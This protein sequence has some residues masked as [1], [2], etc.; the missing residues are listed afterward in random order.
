MKNTVECWMAFSRL[1]G[2]LAHGGWYGYHLEDLGVVADTDIAPVITQNRKSILGAVR[3]FNAQIRKHVDK[4]IRKHLY[5][6]PEKV[7]ITITRKG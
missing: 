3:K 4:S 7:E 5:V 2:F 6:R 1:G